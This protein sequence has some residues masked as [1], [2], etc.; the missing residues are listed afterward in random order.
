MNKRGNIGR[1]EFFSRVTVGAGAV[2]QRLGAQAAGV[3]IVR[4]PADAIA[5]A[6]PSQ[7]AAKEVQDALSAKGISVRLEQRL[8]KA[9]AGD[10]CIL[11][12]GPT[13]SPAPEILKGVGLSVP[14]LPESLVLAPAKAAGRI[15]LLACG[16]DVRGLVYALLELADR[17]RYGDSP[18]DALKLRQPIVEQPA[19][20]VRSI[21]RLFSSDVE[22]KPW[23]NDREMWPAYLSMLAAQRS[24][25]S[26]SASAL[27]TTS[28]ATSPMAISCSPTRSCSP[29]PDTTCVC[30]SCPTP[31]ATA[32]WRCCEFI[33]EQTTA[34]G[35][36][37]QLGIWM[38]GYK[39]IDSPNPNYTIEGLTP[40][41]HG[42]YCR[43]AVRALLKACPEDQRRHVPHPRRERRRGGELRVLEDGLRRR[44]H[45]R[46]QGRNRH[47]R[48]GH[49]PG[50]DRHG[51]GDRLCR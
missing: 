18:L 16:R 6:G 3:C 25:A 39:W 9:A 23:Y 30:R 27:A 28:S 34:R 13:A 48:Q 8:E 15:I 44:G 14:E 7:W 51:A 42:P 36:E 24:T 50:H 37:F 43:D 12:A 26:T 35:M 22:D 10:F 46:S 29:C 4:D 21:T 11:A 31:S 33:S 17:V 2:A 41:T 20:R 47:A 49:G 32:T 5:G 45:L 38:H 1:R 19:N 40:E